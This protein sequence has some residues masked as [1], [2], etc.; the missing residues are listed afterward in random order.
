MSDLT[1][2]PDE[3]LIDDYIETLG[4]IGIC[5]FALGL[6]TK[7]YGKG[8]S[9]EERLKENQNIKATIEAEAKRRGLKIGWALDAV[10]KA[11][12]KPRKHHGNGGT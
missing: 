4:D 7:F 10:N 11:F 8:L 1:N 6:G 5:E 2:I 9:I 3:Q 12:G